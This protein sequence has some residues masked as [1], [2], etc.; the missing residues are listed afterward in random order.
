MA[1][2]CRFALYRLDELDLVT[3]HIVPFSSNP[4]IIEELIDALL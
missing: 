1:Q 4:Y 3:N 2:T